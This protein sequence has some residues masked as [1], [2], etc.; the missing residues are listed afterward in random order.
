MK[1]DTET[2]WTPVTR[3]RRLRSRTPDPAVVEETKRLR[4]TA[5][6]PDTVDSTKMELADEETRKRALVERTEDDDEPAEKYWRA[7]DFVEKAS[8]DELTGTCITEENGILDED[9]AGDTW[10]GCLGAGG[11]LDRQAADEETEKALDSLLAH[12]V[13]D[14][15][16]RRDSRH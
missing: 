2:E 5:P 12:G 7:E 13:V 11:E 9:A 3:R 1:V 8:M 15:R 10:T 16:T 4:S 6:T 14:V